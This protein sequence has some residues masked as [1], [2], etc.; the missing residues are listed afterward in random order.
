MASRGLASQEF[1]EQSFS[2]RQEAAAQFGRVY[3]EPHAVAWKG[4]LAGTLAGLAGSYAMVKFQELWTRLSDET[5]H[6][7]SS[8]KYSPRIQDVHTG[9]ERQEGDDATVQGAE[10]ISEAVLDH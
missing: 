3:V 1:W 6:A 4:A 2:Y 5:T 8:G 9:E 10:R 7:K